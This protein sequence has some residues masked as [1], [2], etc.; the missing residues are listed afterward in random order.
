MELRP[1]RIILLSMDTVR[2]DHVTGYGSATTTPTLGEIAAEGVLFLDSY[3]ASS[4]TIPSHASIFTGLDAIEHG[5]IVDFARIAPDVTTLAEALA[6]A[7]YRTQG[8][9]EGVYV[10]ARFGFDRGFDAYVRRP[11]NGVVSDSLPTLLEWMRS[12]ADEPYFLFLHTYAAHYPYGGFERYR[13]EH[14]ERGLPS[15]AEIRGL[16]RRYSPDRARARGIP[17]ETRLIC[18]LYN[19]LATSRNSMLACGDRYLPAN[20][21]ETPHFELDR[22]AL[23]ASYDERIGHIDRALARIRST[24]LDLGQWEDTLLV[25]TA[26]HGEAFFEHGLP[27]HDYVPFDEVLKVPLVVSYPRLLRSRGVRRVAG[28]TWHLDLMPTIL[29]LAGIPDPGRPQGIDLTPAMLGDTRIPDDR[30]IYPAVLSAPNRPP[31]PLRRAAVQ[32]G[33]KYIE[34]HPRFGNERGYLFDLK[35]DPEE[36]NNL[37]GSR[38]SQFREF[39]ERVVRYGRRLEPHAPVH[40]KTGRPVVSSEEQPGP[41]VDLSAEE[42]EQ[43]RELG[44]VD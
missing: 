32:G 9:H 17:S 28:L 1:G 22:A 34:G 21:P 37:R 43:L 13:R 12:A 10:D 5:V 36:R 20:F 18:T 31:M 6:S 40:Q 23:T 4:Y 27:R 14:P 44:Y 42:V 25:V 41:G 26:D 11:R 2:A 24:L 39:S 8:F 19:H 35:R 38:E 15:D 29:S 3:A 33:L 7:G 30:T 16:H